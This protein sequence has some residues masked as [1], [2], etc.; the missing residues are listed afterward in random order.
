MAKSFTIKPT[1]TGKPATFGRGGNVVR[2]NAN[3][4]PISNSAE[5]FFEENFTG[6]QFNNANGFTWS[7]TNNTAVVSFGGYDALRFRYG[8]DALGE[9]TNSE[10]RFNLGQNLTEL[11][12]EYY[13]YIPSNYVH[14]NDPPNNNK[15]IRIWGDDYNSANKLGAST[16]YRTEFL[17]DNS[18]LGFEYNYKGWDYAVLGFGPEGYT[19][20]YT[21]YGNAMKGVW[22]Q[23]RLHF[24][25][26]S[27]TDADDALMELWLNGTKVLSFINVPQKYDTLRPYWNQGYLMGWSNSGFLDETDFYIR[28]VKFYNTN[29]GWT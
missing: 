18:G 13:L 3:T 27:S 14:R 16:Q 29:P 24:R 4:S 8:P 25:L 2:G 12:I 20:G 19:S 6:T 21:E 7:G 28:N 17:T 9:D 22:T 23:V 1:G 26:V 5:P 15:F 10:Q 11:W